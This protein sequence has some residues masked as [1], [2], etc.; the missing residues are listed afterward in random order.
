MLACGSWVNT[1]VTDPNDYGPVWIRSLHCEPLL[2][3]PGPCPPPPEW[4]RALINV[5]DYTCVYIAIKWRFWTV[6]KWTEA[7]FTTCLSKQFSN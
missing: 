2:T 1:A 6:D 7:N 4:D 3:V 5:I